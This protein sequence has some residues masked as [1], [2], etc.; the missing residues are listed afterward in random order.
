VHE[1]AVPLVLSQALRTDLIGSGAP[2]VK[3]LPN[4]AR[5][6]A[7]FLKTLRLSATVQALRGLTSSSTISCSR[8]RKPLNIDL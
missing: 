3:A 7:A 5:R 4:A 2:N 1:C 8:N 6:N